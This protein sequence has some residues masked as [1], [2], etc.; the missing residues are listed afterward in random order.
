M[1]QKPFHSH[2]M[3]PCPHLSSAP[4]SSSFSMHTFILLCCFGLFH[5]SVVGESGETDRLALLNFKG[6][7]SKDPLRVMSSWNDSIHFCQWKGVFCGRRHQ[8]VTVLDLQSQKLVGSI[9]TL[10]TIAFIM[11]FLKKLAVCVDY[12]S[13]N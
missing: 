9:S 4:P 10:K 8:R 13:C 6:E 11:K 1:K 2:C 3:G 7:I 12:E 5:T